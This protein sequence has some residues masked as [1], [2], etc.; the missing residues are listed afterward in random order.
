[1]KKINKSMVTDVAGLAV[2]SIAAAKV[3]SLKLPINLPAPIQAAIPLL[4]GIMLYKKAGIMGAIAN[5]MIAVGST[6]L[7]GAIAPNLGIG[8]DSMDNEDMISDYMIE[9]SATYALA[10]ADMG[11]TS[12]SLAGVDSKD[13]LNFG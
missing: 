12:Y 6:K 13:S 4:I 9:G 11:G 2:G 3:S 1:M 5:G 7:I 8:S 10:G